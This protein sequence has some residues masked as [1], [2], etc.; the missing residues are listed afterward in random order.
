MAKEIII[1][2]VVHTFKTEVGLINYAAACNCAFVD[3]AEDWFVSYCT[4]NEFGTLIFIRL[5]LCR[6]ETI[7]LDDDAVIHVFKEAG[8]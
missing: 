1:N 3:P 8:Q 6:G 4:V 5:D 7:P 2:G